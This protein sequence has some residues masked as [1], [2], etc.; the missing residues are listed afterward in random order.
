MPLQEAI[1]RIKIN[2]LLEDSGWRFFDDDQG[3]AIL[4]SDHHI[5]IPPSI[6]HLLHQQ[7]DIQ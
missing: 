1:S 3:L 4:I 5:N 2:Q 6:H 7:I